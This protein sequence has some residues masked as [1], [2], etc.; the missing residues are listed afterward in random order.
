MRFQVF[1]LYERRGWRYVHSR[2]CP[3][4]ADLETLEPGI[5]DTGISSRF[6]SYRAMTNDFATGEHRIFIR[7]L[8][9]KDALRISRPGEMIL[10]A[11]ERIRANGDFV[12][13]RWML[14]DEHPTVEK[15]DQ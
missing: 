3:P 10:Q 8:P 5:Y 1:D 15:R 13:K 2:P 4:G 9:A 11:G 12:I 7:I 14:T 6:R